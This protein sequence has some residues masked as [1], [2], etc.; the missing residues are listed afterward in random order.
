MAFPRNVPIVQLRCLEYDR[1][2]HVSINASFDMHPISRGRFQIL[3]E[4]IHN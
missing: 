1:C 2:V 4:E 3:G